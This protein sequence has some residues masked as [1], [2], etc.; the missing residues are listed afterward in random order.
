MSVTTL[1][2]GRPAPAWAERVA[3]LIPLVVLPSGLWR[4]ALVAG[5]PIGASAHGVPVHLGVGES[6]YIVALSLVSEA[7]AL[8]AFGLVRPWGEVLPRWLPL[9]GARRVPPLFAVTVATAGAV[10]LTLIWGY[11]A[12]GVVVDGNDLDFSP[13]GF[14]LLVACYL[15]L[16]LWGPLLLA[17]TVAYHHRRRPP[18]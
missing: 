9:L 8:L 16:L 3:H 13:A 4:I 15:P 18:A 11:A 1:P 2:T 12:W 14:A 6:V 5:V 10:A 7:L 17:L